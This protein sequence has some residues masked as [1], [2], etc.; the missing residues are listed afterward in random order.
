[1]ARAVTNHHL[2][3]LLAEAGY[4]QA[5]SAFARQVN[6]RGQARGLA[7][8]YDAASVYWW[9]RG[10][11]PDDPVPQVIAEVLSRRIRRPVDVDELGLA[12][13]GASS[14]LG[15]TFATGLEQTRDTVAS[16]WRQQVARQDTLSS[17]PFVVAATTDAG[18][19]WHFDPRDP[20]ASRRP[21]RHPVR[22]R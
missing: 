15:L 6:L 7:L 1:M 18:W 22:C 20:D 12:A 17:M 16:L 9:L 13:G 2:H 3:A 8:R 10:R 19:R 11:R 4:A 21:P 14:E 5:R